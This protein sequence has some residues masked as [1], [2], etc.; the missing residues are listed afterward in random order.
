MSEIKRWRHGLP[1]PLLTFFYEVKTPATLKLYNF[2][3]VRCESPPP[4]VSYQR[5]ALNISRSLVA[6]A[7]GLIW[8]VGGD[9]ASIRKRLFQR[10]QAPAP[11]PIPLMVIIWSGGAAAKLVGR[12]AVILSYRWG[13]QRAAG[14]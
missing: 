4:G 6:V 3:V 13:Y 9:V 8:E 2:G 10:A 1:S 5:T 7:S 12:Y 14:N 11:P